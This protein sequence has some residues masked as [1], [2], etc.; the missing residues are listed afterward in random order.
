MLV[1]VHKLGINASF[2]IIILLTANNAPLSVFLNLL[3]F[4]TILSLR[5]FP[6]LA[7]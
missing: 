2:T 1:Y 4:A 3:L 6:P 5:L 7:P